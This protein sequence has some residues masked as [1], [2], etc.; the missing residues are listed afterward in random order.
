MPNSR[1]VAPT[2]AQGR[3]DQSNDERQGGAHSGD[4]TA[5]RNARAKSGAKG[6][7]ASLESNDWAGR[8]GVTSTDGADALK[9][10][11]P[12]SIA[13]P[14]KP[15]GVP[16]P[17]PDPAAVASTVARGLAA[18]VNQ[19]GGT[20][21]LRLQPETLGALRIHMEIERGV[22]GASIEASTPEA[23]D[24]LSKSIDTL[25]SA[26]EAKGLSVDKLRVD[27]AQQNPNGHGGPGSESRQRSDQPAP[28]FEDRANGFAHDAAEG[29]SR[30][31]SEDHGRQGAERRSTHQ[32]RE[33]PGGLA[34]DE[35]F[36][37]WLRVGV[38]A[39]A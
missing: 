37:A 27:L 8:L 33:S 9:A 6:V 25:R 30:G 17:T 2:A 31:W 34:P 12:A 19:K 18:A 24:L 20:I 36:T 10:G 39:L 4:S 11:A 35:S 7:F 21:V 29:R 22:V 38:D 32:Q 16:T 14:G 28:R 1:A 23:R 5:T 3:S 13:Q 26:L 15:A